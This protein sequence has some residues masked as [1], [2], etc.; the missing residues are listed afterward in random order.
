MISILP[1]L[2]E[3]LGGFRGTN[4]KGQRS[5][6]RRGLA[7]LAATAFKS[8]KKAWRLD[9]NFTNR[10][11]VQL[12]FAHQ[13]PTC[14]KKAIFLIPLVGVDRGKV[15]HIFEGKLCHCNVTDFSCIQTLLGSV[16]PSSD[17]WN[18]AY[19]ILN[20]KEDF[21]SGE[22]EV[23]EKILKDSRPGGENKTQKTEMTLRDSSRAQPSMSF[24]IP[25]SSWQAQDVHKKMQMQ[26]PGTSL[27]LKQE[28][29]S[30]LQQP[31]TVPGSSQQ[32]Q[33]FQSQ[34]RGPLIKR[35]RTITPASARL[36]V[37][38]TSDWA[39]L[40]LFLISYLI[41]SYFKNNIEEV[42]EE[43]LPPFGYLEKYLEKIKSLKNK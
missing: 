19:D 27:R 17:F 42:E 36:P 5:E 6:V 15:H 18:L 30:S 12:E 8:D 31:S 3:A 40:I 41:P 16:A 38:M 34:E 7:I 43:Y 21:S 22:A 39:S 37:P 29:F 11:G 35:K 9:A 25:S 13:H 4:L 28:G 14:K 23:L 24:P 10:A 26:V 1:H 32:A 20:G 33:Y 2:T